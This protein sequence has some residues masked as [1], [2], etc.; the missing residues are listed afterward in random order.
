M[1]KR[2]FRSTSGNSHKRAKLLSQLSTFEDPSTFRVFRNIKRKLSSLKF[3]ESDLL[4]MPRNDKRKKN[5]N[6][7]KGGNQGSASGSQASQGYREDEDIEEPQ[8]VARVI[9]PVMEEMHRRNPFGEVDFNDLFQ[10]SAAL[11]FNTIRNE[12]E[13]LTRESIG[14]KASNVIVFQLALTGFKSGVEGV[15]SFQYKGD[16]DQPKHLPEAVK[17]RLK[18]DIH[19]LNRGDRTTAGS[20]KRLTFKRI[21][22][23]YAQN[24]RTELEYKIAAGTIDENKLFMHRRHGIRMEF[25]FIGSDNAVPELQDKQ[26]WIDD[27]ADAAIKE[28]RET[29]PRRSNMTVALLRAKRRWAAER[30][31]TVREFDEYLAN[32]TEEADLEALLGHI[33]RVTT[34]LGGR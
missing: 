1:S 9:N 13:A 31:L 34:A 7:G 3:V 18:D 5:Q 22:D 23:A 6:K 17:K 30:K 19:A 4:N 27:F 2:P 28:A 24:I 33:E 20:G 8:E 15:D 21:C 16:N 10:P 25:A 11:N 32:N 26:N 29:D 12:W 14:R